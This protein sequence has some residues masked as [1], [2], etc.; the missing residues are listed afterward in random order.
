MKY[1]IEFTASGEVIPPLGNGP[2]IGLNMFAERAGDDP[3]TPSVAISAG[4]PYQAENF[5]KQPSGLIGLDDI[6]FP[7]VAVH[8]TGEILDLVGK[9]VVHQHYRNE[10]PQPIEAKYIFPLDEV[11]KKYPICSLK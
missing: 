3:S 4:E 10:R 8:I 7:L 5:V 1:V 2:Y 6:G 9:V 11:Q